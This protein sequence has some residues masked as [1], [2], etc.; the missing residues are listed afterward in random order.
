MKILVDS[1]VLLDIF[2]QDK[3]WFQ[4]SAR[5]IAHHAERDLLSINPIIYAE[6]SLHFSTIEAL[7]DALPETGFPRLPLPWAGGFLAGRCFNQ[8]RKRGGERRSPMPDFY[9]G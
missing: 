5:A 1:N 3:Q 2:T 8:Y 4:W 6:V 7:D 9:I